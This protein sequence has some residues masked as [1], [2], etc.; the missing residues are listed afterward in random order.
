MRANFYL[1]IVNKAI[2]MQLT[3]GVTEIFR[4]ERKHSKKNNKNAGMN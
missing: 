2:Y 1:P 3:S 4:V